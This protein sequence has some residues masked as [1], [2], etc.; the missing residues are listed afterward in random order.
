MTVR[1]PESQLA[2]LQVFGYTEAEAR[3]L[4]IG[5]RDLTNTV[6]EVQYARTRIVCFEYDL[7]KR[8]Q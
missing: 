4:H 3:F 6:V 1:I 8:G 2:K 5:A 7:P